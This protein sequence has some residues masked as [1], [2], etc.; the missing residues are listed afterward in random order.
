MAVER[1]RTDGFRFAVHR[2]R[3]E[4]PPERVDDLVERLPERLRGT[5]GLCRVTPQELLLLCAGPTGAF[6]VVRARVQSIWEQCWSDSGRAGRAPEL[7]DDRLEIRDPEDAPTFLAT[8]RG[9]LARM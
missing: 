4:G 1:H 5:D 6:L 8:A 9:W 3:F 7:A 2:L